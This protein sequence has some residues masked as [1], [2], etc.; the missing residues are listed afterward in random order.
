M[1]RIFVSLLIA[2]SAV[3]GTVPAVAQSYGRLG[4][5]GYFR[6][7]GSDVVD[8][9]TGYPGRLAD[10]IGEQEMRHA[11]MVII[12][13]DI[14]GDDINV[15]RKL[16]SR[17]N[18]Y[19]NSDRSVDNYVDLDLSRARIVSGGYYN[20][21]KRTTRDEIGEYM[22]ASCGALRSIVLP[23][24]TTNIRRNA[25]YFCSKLEDVMMPRGVRAIEDNAFYSCR[26]LR[27]IDLPE[28]IERIGGEAFSGCSNL[29]EVY[30]PST[31]REIGTEAFRGCP[32]KRIALPAGLESLGH[33]ALSNTKITQLLIPSRCKLEGAIGY[34]P[35]LTRIDVEPG[36][37]LYI[38]EDGILYSDEGRTLRNYPTGRGGDVK[39]PE[40]VTRIGAFAFENSRAVSVYL[41]ESCTSIGK[42]AF[43]HCGSMATISFGEALTSIDEKAFYD[44]GALTSFALP[45]GMTAVKNS[46]FKECKRLMKVELP[47][48]ITDIEQDAFRDCAVL[49]EINLEEGLLTIGKE[50]FRGC[51]ALDNVVVPSTVKTL[52]FKAFNEC[53]NLTSITLKEGLKVIEE[54]ALDNCNLLSIDIPASVQVI[55]KKIIDKN[56]NMQKIIV[57]ATTPPA[58]KS[59]SEKKVPL[60]VPAQSVDLYKTTKPWKNY[61]NILPLE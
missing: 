48:S 1:K 45:E 12:E 22:F 61:K 57:R 59:D 41:P 60:Y 44:C 11:R 17:T 27:R 3:G 8:I 25:F 35:S 28:G 32:F 53:K 20:S 10:R 52:S 31:L 50:A 38:S 49:R 40:G 30:L 46:M 56:K 14:N 54:S 29:P 34:T 15:L 39:V 47:K 2:A 58:L 23:E 43:Q 4:S 19:D 18:C 55:D 36:N 21:G 42:G 26:E 5:S 37:A 33:S 24:W 13:G 51:K 16:C 6:R 9:R 7:G